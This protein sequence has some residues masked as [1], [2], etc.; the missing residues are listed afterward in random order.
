M[1][2]KEKAEY[3]IDKYVD[4][5]D[6]NLKECDYRFAKLCALIAVDEIIKSIVFKD[7]DERYAFEL[8]SNIYYWTEVK[9]EI[10]RFEF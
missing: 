5:Q 9:K 4:L 3:L 10:L 6:E 2:Q 8:G 1:I 7:D